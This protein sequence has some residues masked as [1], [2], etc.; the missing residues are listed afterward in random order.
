MNS[1]TF[2]F[3]KAV[4][5]NDGAQALKKAIA[6]DPRLE[7]YLVPRTLMGWLAS[8]PQYE[9]HVP[10]VREVYLSFAK[11]EV[12]FEGSIGVGSQPVNKFNAP[13]SYALVAEVALALGYPAGEFEGTD[14]MLVSVGR[15]VDALL[16]AQQATRD[17]GKSSVDLP[18]QTAKPRQAE[19]PQEPVKPTKQPAMASKP[20]L[21]KLSMVKVELDKKSHK[22]KTCGSS[23]FKSDKFVGCICFHDLAKNCTTTS[24]A[25]GIVLEF[26]KSADSRAVLTLI[27]ELRN[28]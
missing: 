22:C 12:G 9:G 4:L 20:K 5:G 7:H 16:K 17:L 23:L 11:S 10:G 18:G 2:S 8:R 1:T 28:A 26:S 27:K 14:R 24:Y 19:G 6:R 3:L 13:D 15:S 21:P 25:D